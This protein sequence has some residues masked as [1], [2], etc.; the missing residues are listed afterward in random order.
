MAQQLTHII[1]DD[2]GSRYHTTRYGASLT[3]SQTT[4]RGIVPQ[5]SR[6]KHHRSTASTGTS[7]IQGFTIVALQGEEGVAKDDAT[8][9]VEGKSDEPKPTR[10]RGRRF[11]P[12]EAITTHSPTDYPR[13]VGEEHITTLTQTK[14]QRALEHRTVKHEHG[15]LVANFIAVM[16]TSPERKRARRGH[17]SGQRPPST[18]HVMDEEGE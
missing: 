8:T 4:R 6:Y 5:R 1:Y 9:P 17:G 14:D 18:W 7:I 12:K 11:T 10:R 13:G 15:R 3:T 2:T 16:T